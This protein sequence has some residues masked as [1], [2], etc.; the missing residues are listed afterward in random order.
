ML[1]WDGNGK[2]DPADVG[3]SIAM[4]ERNSE[5]EQQKKPT[6]GGCF[7]TCLMVILAIICIALLI[8]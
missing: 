8:L 1:D 7:S 3:M 4:E 6:G 5:L 2:I